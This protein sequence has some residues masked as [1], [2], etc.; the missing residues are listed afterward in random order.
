[1]DNLIVVLIVILLLANLA[2]LYFQFKKDLV[3]ITGQKR[4]SI[5]MILIVQYAVDVL[6]QLRLD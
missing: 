2:I 3:S 6:R 4:L 5:T 1:M